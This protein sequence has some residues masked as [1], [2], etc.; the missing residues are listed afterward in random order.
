M[1][2]V[3]A[4]LH[5]YTIGLSLHQL[6]PSFTVHDQVLP[7]DAKCVTVGFRHNVYEVVIDI[8]VGES[9]VVGSVV[10]YLKLLLARHHRSF[11]DLRWS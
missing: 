8:V 6:L 7:V 1:P 9:R 4:L 2:N 5:Q 3:T 11:I 10:W